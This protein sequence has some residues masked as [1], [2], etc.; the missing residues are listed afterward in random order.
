MRTR[1]GPDDTR[2]LRSAVTASAARCAASI[3][4]NRGHD[5]WNLDHK[6]RGWRAQTLQRRG[7]VRRTHKVREREL[8]ARRVTE[9]RRVFSSEEEPSCGQWHQTGLTLLIMCTRDNEG[10]IVGFK[11]AGCCDGRAHYRDHALLSKDVRV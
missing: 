5:D 7:Q 8:H 11:G 1:S 9:S 10:Q 4:S 6:G 3:A 2:L